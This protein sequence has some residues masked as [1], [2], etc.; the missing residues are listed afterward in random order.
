MD[1]REFSKTIWFPIA[2]VAVMMTIIGLFSEQIQALNPYVQFLIIGLPLTCVILFYFGRLHDGWKFVASLI[3]VTYSWDL[4]QPPYMVNYAGQ[5]STQP[6]LYGTSIDYVVGTF[7]SG[8]GIAGTLLYYA[9]YL[10]GFAVLF[11]VA[12]ALSGKKITFIGA[13]KNV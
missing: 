9:T 2:F 6:L 7:F 3:L 10:L 11:L 4:L 5:L 12:I 8:F 1:L 13:R